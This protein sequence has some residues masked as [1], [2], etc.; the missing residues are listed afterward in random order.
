MGRVRIDSFNFTVFRPEHYWYKGWDKDRKRAVDVWHLKPDT[1]STGG[2]G[3]A[4]RIKR[5]KIGLYLGVM[6][7]R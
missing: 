7:N 6:W 5:L 3:L 2:T 4:I 1:Y